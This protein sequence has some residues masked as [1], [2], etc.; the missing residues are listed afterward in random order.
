MTHSEDLGDAFVQTVNIDVQVLELVAQAQQFLDDADLGLQRFGEVSCG[1]V[2]Y[3]LSHL[4][5]CREDENRGWWKEAASN[6]WTM[7]G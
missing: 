6:K 4:E 2:V 7:G 1:H 5:S 3:L